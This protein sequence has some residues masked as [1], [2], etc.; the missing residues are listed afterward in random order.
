MSLWWGKGT[1]AGHEWQCE[2]ATMTMNP[3]NLDKGK[4]KEAAELGRVSQVRK[5]KFK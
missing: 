3:A 1:Q 2:K 4:P 5:G